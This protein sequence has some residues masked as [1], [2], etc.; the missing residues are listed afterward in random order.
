MGVLLG[1]MGARVP[2]ARLLPIRIATEALHLTAPAGFV[3]ADTATAALLDAHCRVS[4]SKG[5]ILAVARK[6][7]VMRAHAAYIVLGTVCGAAVLTAVSQRFLGGRWLVAAAGAAAL[8]PLTLSMALGAGFTGR[9]ALAR[10]HGALERLPWATVRGLVAR[11]KGG[12]VVADEHLA[13]IGADPRATWSAAGW[14]LGCWIFESIET[15]LVLWLVGGPA[16]LAMALAVEVALSLVRSIGNVAPA[17]LGLQEA[18][19]A[20]LLTA[21]G[22]DV[23]T[24]AAFVLLKR[25]KELVWIGVGYALL[26]G[27]RRGE[28]IRGV[29]RDAFAKA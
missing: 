11:W 21:M 19:Y 13:R 2:F 3:V 15:A 14:F 8:L 7:L 26:A 9:P 1:A 16:S 4:L 23:D 6:W 17:G 28:P 20:T 10:L 5:A 29:A 12:A 22:V 27:M 18:G 24:A 25:G